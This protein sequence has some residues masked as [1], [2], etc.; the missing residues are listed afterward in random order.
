MHN[1]TLLLPAPLL[2]SLFLLLTDSYRIDILARLLVEKIPPLLSITSPQI[3]DP[4]LHQLPALVDPEPQA[5]LSSNS[6]TS[7]ASSD[8]ASPSRFV[9]LFIELGPLQS[10]YVD[11]PTNTLN[12]FILQQ[13]LNVNPP[14]T[15]STIESALHHNRRTLTYLLNSSPNLP[16]THLH[17]TLRRM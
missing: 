1:C 6:L 11:I 7:H 14:D 17:D 9:R 4:L 15:L 10:A 2:D 12:T 3:V 13:E 16:I 5:A 8:I